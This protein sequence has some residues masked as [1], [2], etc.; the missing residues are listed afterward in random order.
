MAYFAI[1]HTT[2][3]STNDFIDKNRRIT[4][5]PGVNTSE[6]VYDSSK[7]KGIIQIRKELESDFFKA[8]FYEDKNYV[9]FID[10]YLSERNGKN[11]AEYILNSFLEKGNAFIQDLNGEYN[12]IIYNIKANSLKVFNDRF[13]CRPF[14]Y[15]S[16][17]PDFVASNEIKSILPYIKKDI[18]EAGLLEFILFFHNV[19][20]RTIYK[21]VKSMKPASIW[22]GQD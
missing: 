16:N 3:N 13:T 22:Y 8:N 11:D 21:A 9:V 7:F 2:K 17:G 10:G 12:I 18:S 19:Q 6:F 20:E 1:F 15:H 5:V 4:F 14:Y